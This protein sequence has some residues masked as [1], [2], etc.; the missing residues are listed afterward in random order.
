MRKNAAL[1]AAAL[2]PGVLVAQT[3]AGASPTQ[4]LRTVDRTFV[5]ATEATGNGRDMDLHS[6]P[7]IVYPGVVDEVVP[8]FLSVSSGTSTL[9]SELVAVRAAQLTGLGA[10]V[11]RPESTR[12]RRG[13][14]Q[15]SVG[16]AE[17][18]EPRRA[19]GPVGEER[20]L[21][22]GRPRARAR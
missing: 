7:H 19:A 15:P 9:D 3:S 4:S 13:A 8:G 1:L 21:Q 17:L 2:L 18:E 12:T 20:R 11:L 16:S 14:P 10:R 22:G 6:H 5:C